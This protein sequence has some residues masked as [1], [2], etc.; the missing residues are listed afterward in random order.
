MAGIQQSDEPVS[1][2]ILKV[3]PGV[4]TQSLDYTYINERNRA[5]IDIPNPTARRVLIKL[6][7]S[8]GHLPLGTGRELWITVDED[9]ESRPFGV[10]DRGG[11][12]GGKRGHHQGGL[13]ARNDLH[14]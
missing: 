14:D 5:D 2:S 12:G 9:A 4:P 6:I 1:K 13:D 10:A 7:P 11:M 8:L 3:L